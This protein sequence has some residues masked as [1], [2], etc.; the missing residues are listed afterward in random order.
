MVTAD[1]SIGDAASRSGCTQ[2]TIRYYEEI[3]LLAGVAR[4]ENGRRVY[5]QTNIERLLLIRRCRDFGLSIEQ[6]R[7]L[8]VAIARNAPD[9]GSVR[10]LILT[11]VAALRAKRLQLRSLEV[12]L[13]GLAASCQPDCCVPGADGCRVV[14]DISKPPSS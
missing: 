13:L 6:I 3:D 14:V 4:G 11:H 5:N 10:D 8:T 12:S 7:E 9:C 1:V 2:A